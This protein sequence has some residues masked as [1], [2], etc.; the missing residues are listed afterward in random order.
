MCV[1][2]FRQRA[3]KALDERLSKV[4]HPPQQ[5]SWPSLDDEGSQEEDTTTGTTALFST[6]TG[7]P[8]PPPGPV[9]IEMEASSGE[10]A[11]QDKKTA[12]VPLTAAVTKADS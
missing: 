8:L 2:F 10:K 12:V 9:A 1:F 11:A 4:E 5:S 7:T 6:P 3:L